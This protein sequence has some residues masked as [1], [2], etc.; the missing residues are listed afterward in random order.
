[1][2]YRRVG[3]G[4]PCDR[5]QASEHF[6]ACDLLSRGLLVTKPLNINGPHDLHA[7][8]GKKWFTFQVKSGKV[9]R[10]TGTLR[11]NHTT[12]AT[13]DIIVAVDIVG[14]RVRYL[15]RNISKLPPELCDAAF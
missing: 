10:K 12:G 15:P 14:K 2:V 6:V 7:K 11:P 1:M 8:C 13:S 3:K 9:N 5:G 4:T